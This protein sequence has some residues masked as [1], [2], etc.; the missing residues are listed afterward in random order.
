MMEGITV[1]KRKSKGV[2]KKVH[3]RICYRCYARAYRFGD[4]YI[5]HRC[6]EIVVK[7]G[8]MVFENENCYRDNEWRRLK[9]GRGLL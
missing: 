7:D 4:L 6:K 9:R 5:C 1:D 8:V 3:Y 2:K